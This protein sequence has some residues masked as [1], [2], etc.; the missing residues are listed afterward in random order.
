MAE[1]QIF[2]RGYFLIA[3]INLILNAD[4]FFSMTF[5]IYI[6][7]YQCRQEMN[8]ITTYLKKEIFD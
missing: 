2:F 1:V 6:C 3:M 8:Q 5:L 4:Q 7:T